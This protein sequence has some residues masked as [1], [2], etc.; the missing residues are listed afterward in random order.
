MSVEE[1]TGVNEGGAENHVLDFQLSQLARGSML[2]SF[3]KSCIL[4][5]R[6]WIVAKASHYGNFGKSGG[7]GK[8]RWMFLINN[9]PRNNLHELYSACQTQS[10]NKA[11]KASSKHL[12]LEKHFYE[13]YITDRALGLHYCTF[14]VLK[15]ALWLHRGIVYSA[16]SRNF[17]CCSSELAVV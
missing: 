7:V 9:Q 12:L 1:K 15:E 5:N 11:L 10:I 16:Q 14:S 2:T 8:S 13:T 17:R 4:W 3:S 6:A